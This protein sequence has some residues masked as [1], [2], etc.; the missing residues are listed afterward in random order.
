MENDAY[1]ESKVRD[2]LTITVESYL[3]VW[4]NVRALSKFCRFVGT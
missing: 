1:F 2:V 3:F 4:A